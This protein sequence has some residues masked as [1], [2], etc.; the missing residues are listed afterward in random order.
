M[1]AF[2]PVVVFCSVDSAPGPL[3]EDG[4]HGERS[5]RSEG[6]APRL[7]QMVHNFLSCLEGF[8]AEKYLGTFSGVI[9][10]GLEDI[11]PGEH[12]GTRV[13]M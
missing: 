6:D 11:F 13:S 7:H 4:P 9:W 5:S 10:S 12:P 2:P 3:A 8:A 1:K